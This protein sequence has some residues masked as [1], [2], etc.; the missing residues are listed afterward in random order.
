MD[1]LVTIFTPTYNRAHILHRCY[2]SLCAQPDYDFK[3]L[4][5]D[6]GSTDGTDDRAAEWIRQEKRF[7]IR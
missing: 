3:W 4:I 6:D 1:K 2:E 5:V 7:D